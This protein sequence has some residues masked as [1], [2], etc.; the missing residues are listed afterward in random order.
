MCR[1][2][3]LRQST[4]D[5]GTFGYLV[6]QKDGAA[7]LQLFT[8]ELPWRDNYTRISCIP[9]GSYKCQ[10]WHSVKYPNNYNV[11]NVPGRS[12]ILF[13][14]GNFSGARDKGYLTNVEGCI[15]V[16]RCLG[17]IKGQKAVLSSRPAM[18]ALRDYIGENF[19]DLEIQGVG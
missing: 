12:A 14:S 13:H 10:P 15:L 2:L 5:Q 17:T 9:S 4:S 16:G 8:G 1:V 19:F 7:P 18:D 11:M 3:L 6:A